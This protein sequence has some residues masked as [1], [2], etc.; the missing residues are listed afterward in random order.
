MVDVPAHVG[1]GDVDGW[2]STARGKRGG[3]KDMEERETGR[4]ILVDGTGNQSNTRLVRGAGE[5]RKP[6][7][8]VPANPSFR[9]A[10]CSHG[11]PVAERHA[12]GSIPS[13]PYPWV[14]A[15]AAR[16]VRCVPL[17]SPS[18]FSFRVSREE[19]LSLPPTGPSPRTLPF[20][21]GGMRDKPPNTD[22]IERKIRPL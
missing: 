12:F 20:L 4:G 6:V 22:P 7:A 14:T 8:V 2:R 1:R 16:R 19:T 21:S 18:S 11:N 17:R 9:D 15:T 10:P 5:G 3:R 13:H